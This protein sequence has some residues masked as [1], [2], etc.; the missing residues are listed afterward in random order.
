M[1]SILNQYDL[2]V[3]DTGTLLTYLFSVKSNLPG[4]RKYLKRVRERK[5]SL[6][7]K[8]AQLL[9]EVR[10]TRDVENTIIEFGKYSYLLINLK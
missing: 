9:V 2:F 1:F 5:K 10:N 4:T 7:L 8:L 6:G 3:L